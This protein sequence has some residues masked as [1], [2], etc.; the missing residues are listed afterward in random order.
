M[1]ETPLSRQWW[2]GA[3]LF[4]CGCATQGAPPPAPVAP[5]ATPPSPRVRW[6]HFDQVRSWE[7]VGGAFRIQGHLVDADHAVVRVSPNARDAYQALVA[8]SSAPDGTL[9]AAFHEGGPDAPAGGPVYVMQ[10]S[11]GA[12]SY[13]VLDAEGGIVEQNPAGCDGCHSGAV[14]DRLFGPPRPELR[15]RPK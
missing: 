3:A 8:D 7:P 14:A 9:V 10:K 15:S 6:P 2:L 13:L 4:V 12:W 5:A 11:E 1:R